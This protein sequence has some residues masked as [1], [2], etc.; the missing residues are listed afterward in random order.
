MICCLF[1]LHIRKKA[2][3][4]SIKAS[5]A[6][7]NIHTT[8]KRSD[9][10]AAGDN[11]AYTHPEKEIIGYRNAAFDTFNIVKYCVIKHERVNFAINL[12]SLLV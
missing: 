1:N 4:D 9:D 6:I 8:E 5:N 3:R 11:S 12:S 10:I 7:E 2:I